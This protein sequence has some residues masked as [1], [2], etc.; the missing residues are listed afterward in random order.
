M[1]TQQIQEPLITSVNNWSN[2]SETSKWTM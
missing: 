2:N 1:I